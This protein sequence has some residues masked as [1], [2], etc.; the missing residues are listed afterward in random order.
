MNLPSSLTSVSRSSRSRCRS[1]RGSRGAS[2]F[3]RPTWCQLERLESRR[4]LSALGG[5]PFVS[6]MHGL[7]DGL[8]IQI[9]GVTV[10]VHGARPGGTGDEMLPLA[11]AIR[12]VGESTSIENASWLLDYD[13]SA[14]GFDPVQSIL[15]NADQVGARGELVLLYDWM[16]GANRSSHGFAEAAGDELFHMLIGLG[17]VDLDPDTA[18]FPRL[19][20]IGHGTGAVVVSKAVERLAFFGESVQ[21]VTYLDPIDWNSAAAPADGPLAGYGAAIWSNV[22]EADV[23]YQTRGANGFWPGLIDPSIPSIPSPTGRPIPGAFNYQLLDELPEN[24]IDPT[25]GYDPVNL[26]GDHDYVWEGFYLSTVND[27]QPEDNQADDVTTDTPAPQI[28]IDT[29][30]AGYAFSDLALQDVMPPPFYFENPNRGDWMEGVLYK[31]GDLVLSGDDDVLSEDD[32]FIALRTHTA[33]SADGT[34]D[35]A[36]E[37]QA[38]MPDTPG[39]SAIWIEAPPSHERVLLSSDIK[40]QDHRNSPADFVQLDD[41]IGAPNYAGLLERGLTVDDVT[42]ARWS[43]LWAPNVIFNGDLALP[44]QVSEAGMRSVPGWV[45]GSQMPAVLESFFAHATAAGVPDPHLAVGT[46]QIVTVVNSEVRLWDK[47]GVLLESQPLDDLL[48]DNDSLDDGAFDPWVIRDPY[49]GQFIVIAIEVESGTVNSDGSGGMTKGG[50]GADQ[51]NLLIAVSKTE[52]PVSL[53]ASAG[54]DWFAYK[55]EGTHDFGQGLARIDYPKVAADADSIYVTGNYA[56]FGDK[57]FQ[58]VLVQRFDKATLLAG[59]GAM[60][61]EI[62]AETVDDDD[63]VRDAFT[64]QPVQ[65]FDRDADAPQLFIEAD[66]PHIYTGAPVGDPRAGLRIW[67]MNEDDELTM[68]D[69]IAAPFSQHVGG[70]RQGASANIETLSARLMNAVWRNGSIWTAHT[71]NVGGRARVRWYEVGTEGG[72]DLVQR[73]DIDPGEAND[74]FMPAIAVTDDGQVGM[75]YTLSGFDTRPVMMFTGRTANDPD[76]FMLPGQTIRTSSDVYVPS[77]MD[78]SEERWGDYGGIDVDPTDGETLWVHHQYSDPELPFSWGTHVAALAFS[79]GPQRDPLTGA[80]ELSEDASRLSH[81]TVFVPPGATRLEVDVKRTALSLDDSLQVLLDLEPLDELGGDAFF[82]LDQIDAGFT[83][84]VFEVPFDEDVHTLTFR[85]DGGAGAIGSSVLIRDVRFAGPLVQVKAGDVS[86]I[87]VL[88][89]TGGTSVTAVTANPSH[90]VLIDPD[91]SVS[92]GVVHYAPELNVTD[93]SAEFAHS[94]SFTVTVDGEDVTVH[95]SVA[96]GHS[97]SGVNAVT[98]EEGEAVGSVFE[99]DVTN[100]TVSVAQVQH[101][102]R[103]L[104]FTGLNGATFDVD[105]SVE[106]LDPFTDAIQ[107]FVAATDPQGDG[108]DPLLED[109]LIRAGDDAHRWLNSSNAPR[110]GTIREGLRGPDIANEVFATSWAA[111]T[112]ENAVASRPE[113]LR[114][115]AFEVHGAV[116][117]SEYPDEFPVLHDFGTGHGAGMDIDW[118]LDEQLLAAAASPGIDIEFNYSFDDNGFFDPTSAEGAARREVMEAAAAFFE[119][120]QDD[121]AAIIPLGGDTWEASFFD[122]ADGSENRALLVEPNMLIPRDTIVVFAGGGALSGTDLAKAAVGGTTASGSAAFRDAAIRRGQP[123]PSRDFARWGGSVIFDSDPPQPWHT[124][125]TI[126]PPADELDLLTFAIHELGHLLGF[127]QEEF[128]PW[129]SL[130]VTGDFLGRNAM[131]VNLPPGPVRLAGVDHWLEIVVPPF[132]RTS[133]VNF[134]GASALASMNPNFAPGERVRP[135]VLDFAALT[136]IGWEHPTMD[137]IMDVLAFHQADGRGAADVKGIRIGGVSGNPDFPDIRAVLSALGVPDVMPGDGEH[138][139]FSI[140]LVPPANESIISPQEQEA[141]LNTL[142]ILRDDVTAAI[143]V[144][145]ALQADLPVTSDGSPSEVSVATSLD[146]ES[147]FA[148]VIFESVDEYFNLTSEPTFGGLQDV[149]DDLS[150]VLDHDD[151]E[152]FTEAE[153]A[154]EVNVENGTVALDLEL[155]VLQVNPINRPGSET[156]A[157]LPATAIDGVESV[158]KELTVGALWP[159]AITF[160]RSDSSVDME[161]VFFASS[162]VQFEISALS[163]HHPVGT[164]GTL[165]VEIGQ[166]TVVLEGGIRLTFDDAD[167]DTNGTIEFDELE[168]PFLANKLTTDAAGTVTGERVGTVP[169]HVG[170]GAPAP[171]AA[172]PEPDAVA[173]SHVPAACGLDAP[174]HEVSVTFQDD[175]IFDGQ[176]LTVTRSDGLSELLDRFGQFSAV[177]VYGAIDALAGLLRSVA[178]QMDIPGGIPFVAGELSANV[179]FGVIADQMA[180]ALIDSEGN[181]QFTT[182]SGMIDR[183][184]TAGGFA[185]DEVQLRCDDVESVLY[186]DLDIQ[187]D[188]NVPVAIDFG[189]EQGPLTINATVDSA[190][191][192]SIDL[193]LSVGFDFSPTTQPDELDE[194]GLR[195]TPLSDLNGLV[196]V[197]STPAGTYDVEVSTASSGAVL[198]TAD[199]YEEV[200]GQPGTTVLDAL[201]TGDIPTEMMSAFAGAGQTLSNPVL[202]APDGQATQDLFAWRIIDGDSIWQ[203]QKRAADLEVRGPIRLLDLSSL[204]E[205]STVADALNL[206]D[207]LTGGDV[208]GEVMSDEA[209]NLMLVFEDD[210]HP[211]PE[212]DPDPDAVGDFYIRRYENSRTANDLGIAG[213]DFRTVANDLL[214]D[215]SFVTLPPS[216]GDALLDRLFIDAGGG[217]TPG[218]LGLTGSIDAQQITLAASAFGVGAEVQNGRLQVDVET[219]LSIADPG[220]GGVDGRLYLKEM[221]AGSIADVADVVTTTVTGSGRLPVVGANDQ[222]NNLLFP[223]DDPVPIDVGHPE[224]PDEDGPEVVIA[225]AAAGDVDVQAN[226]LFTDRFGGFANFKLQDV[227]VSIQELV[228]WLQSSDLVA[229]NAPLPGVARSLG[230]MLDGAGQLAPALDVLCKDASSLAATIEQDI[231]PLLYANNNPHNDADNA[232]AVGALANLSAHLTVAQQTAANRLIRGVIAAAQGTDVPTM[233]DQLTASLGGLRALSDSL[234][235][236]INTTQLDAALDVLAISFPSLDRLGGLIGQAAPLAG[237]VVLSLIDLDGDAQTPGRGLRFEI[238][239]TFSFDEGVALDFDYDEPD[240]G[241]LPIGFESEPEIGFDLQASFD[242]DFAIDLTSSSDEPLDRLLVD[243]GGEGLRFSLDQASVTT[244]QAF[245]ASIGGAAGFAFNNIVASLAS[246]GGDDPVVS[247]ALADQGTIPLAQANTNETIDAVFDLDFDFSHPD[248]TGGT[249]ELELDLGGD[250]LQA[251]NVFPPLTEELEDAPQPGAG[252]NLALVGDGI[253]SFFQ[254]LVDSLQNSVLAP[255]PIL[256]DVEDLISSSNSV[257]AQLTAV[258]DAL[259]VSLEGGTIP[260]T[261]DLRSLIEDNLPDVVIGSGTGVEIPGGD[262]DDLILINLDLDGSFTI[263]TGFDLGFDAFVFEVTEDTTVELVVTYEISIG[264]GMHPVEGPFFLVNPNTD[265]INLSLDVGLSEDAAMVVD[266]FLLQASVTE[267]EDGPTTGIDGTVSLNLESDGNRLSFS[268]I[269]AAGIAGLFDFDYDLHASLG[270]TV[271]AGAGFEPDGLPHLEVDL[272]MDNWHI[273]GSGEGVFETVPAPDF[274]F[275]NARIDVGDFLSEVIGPIAGNISDFVSPLGPILDFFGLEVPLISQ[276]YQILGQDPVTVLDMVAMFGDGAETAAEFVEVVSII[277][278]VVDAAA[279]ADNGLMIHFGNFVFNDVR[280]G[281]SFDEETL[282]LSGGSLLTTDISISE[283]FDLGGGLTVSVGGGPPAP[284]PAEDADSA[285]VTAVVGKLNEIGVHFPLFENPSAFFGLLLGGEVDLVTYDGPKLGIGYQWTSPSIG[286]VAPPAPLFVNIF[287]GFEAFVDIL[288]FGVD[289]HGLREGNSLL[290]GFYLRDEGPVV[291]LGAEFGVAA[292]LNLGLVWAGIAGAIRAE[293]GAGWNSLD[294]DTKFRFSELEARLEQGLHC[295][296]DLAGQLSVILE[297]YAGLG[298]NIFGKKLTIFELEL[299]I[300]NAILL[301]FEVGCPLPEPPVL[302]HVED[303]V[304]VGDTAEDNVLVANIGPHAGRRQTGAADGD[305]VLAILPSDDPNDP[306]GTVIVEGFGESQ[307]FGPNH[308]GGQAVEYIL[309]DAGIGNDQITIDAAVTIPVM[310]IGGPGNDTLTAGGGIATINGGDGADR[311]TGGDDNDEIHGGAGNDLIFGGDG[312]DDL[313]GDDG[314]DTI[315]AEDGNDNAW[316]GDGDDRLDGSIGTDNLR[317]DGG[318]DQISGGPD[319]DD[320]WGGPGDDSLTGNAGDDDLFGDAGKDVLSGGAGSDTLDGGAGDDTLIGDEDGSSGD[321]VGATY[322]DI[323]TGGDGSDVLDGGRGDDTYRFAAVTDGSSEKDRISEPAN[324][325]GD[326]ADVLDFS[327]L[328]ADGDGDGNMDE[329]AKE[330]GVRVNLF[331]GV[332]RH[333]QRKIEI[334]GTRWIEHVIGGAGPDTFVDNA[335]S[336]TFTGGGGNDVYF[337]GHFVGQVADTQLDRVVEGVGD[338]QDEINFADLPAG[339]PVHVDL[340]DGVASPAATTTAIALHNTRTVETAVQG[341]KNHIENITGGRAADILRGNASANIIVGNGAD[342]TIHGEGGG[343]TIR[344]NAGQDTINGGSGPDTIYGGAGA[345]DINGGA[346]GD[347]IFG[348]GGNDTIRGQG[349]QDIIEGGT[350]EDLIFGNAANDT[351]GGGPDPDT[352]FG[353]GGTD[354]IDGDGGADTIFGGNGRP[355]DQG[356][357][358]DT[359]DILR[360]NG[361]A[362]LLFGE[363]GGDTID[364]GAGRDFIVGDIG[365]DRLTGGS[366]NDFLTGGIDSGNRL[367]DPASPILG[368]G[369]FGDWLDGEGNHDLVIGGLPADYLTLQTLV[370]DNFKDLFDRETRIPDDGV[371]DFTDLLSVYQADPTNEAFL[372][373]LA[374]Y[375]SDGIDNDDLLHGGSGNDLLAGSEGDDN[376]YGDH[377]LDTLFGWRIGR[378]DVTTTDRYEGGPDNDLLCGTHGAN[379]MVGGTSDHNIHYI[380]EDPGDPGGPHA[381]GYD[382]PACIDEDP[383]LLDPDPV[384]IHGQKW[385]DANGNGTRDVDEAGQDGWTIQLRDEEGDLIASTV[386]SS[387]DLNEDGIIDPITERGLYW[388]RDLSVEGGNVEEFQAATYIVSEAL[389]NGF[390]QTQPVDGDQLVDEPGVSVTAREMELAVSGDTLTTVVYAVDVDEGQTASGVN[391]GNAPLASI[392]GHKFEDLNNDGVQDVGEPVLAGWEVTLR[393]TGDDEFEMVQVTDGFGEYRF[394]NLAPGH[395]IVEETDNQ[396]G[397][398]WINS[399]PSPT[400]GFIVRHV[401]VDFGDIVGDEDFGN[402]HLTTVQGHVWNDSDGDRQQDEDEPPVLHVGGPPV[403]LHDVQLRN[404]NGDV[405]DSVS[406][407]ED[408]NYFFEGVYPGFYTVE[409]DSPL[410]W[411]QTFPGD[412]T[413][414]HHHIL[415]ESSG[416]FEGLDF[417]TFERGVASGTKFDDL[418]AD[419]NQDVDE[420]TELGGGLI[421]WND[422]DGDGRMDEQDEPGMAGVVIYVD[423][424]DNGILDVGEEGEPLEPTATTVDDIPITPEDETG[425]YDFLNLDPGNY[426]IREVV[427]DGFAQTFPDFHAESGRREHRIT[428]RSGS[429]EFGQQSIEGLDFGNVA[430][431]TIDGVKWND[432]NGNG[433]RDA[434]ELGLGNW[435]I[436]LDLDD[437]GVLTLD[438]FGDPA[439]PFT[440]TRYDDPDTPQDELGTYRFEGVFPGNYTVRE[441]LQPNWLQTW[442]EAGALPG[443]HTVNVTGGATFSDRNFGNVRA[444]SIHGTKWHD[445]DADGVFDTY[446]DG[447]A[448]VTIYLDLND[449]RMRDPGEPTQVT[450][451]DDPATLE[452]ETGMYWFDGLLPGTYVIRE[453]E[454]EGYVQTYPEGTNTISDVTFT[455]A[456]TVNQVNGFIPGVWSATAVGQPW[457]VSYTF[458]PT[459]PDTLVAN[460]TLGN[461]EAIHEFTLTVGGASVTQSPNPANTDIDVRDEQGFSGGIVI[462]SFEKGPQQGS[463]ALGVNAFGTTLNPE[464]VVG[465]SRDLWSVREAGDGI[466][467]AEVR[468]GALHILAAGVDAAVS[469]TWDGGVEREIGDGAMY[470]PRADP[471]AAVDID[472]LGADNAG[473]NLSQSGANDA[474]FVDILSL[475]GT[476]SVRVDVWSDGGTQFQSQVA[477]IAGAAPQTLI[478]FTAAFAGIDWT[479]VSALK[480]TVD[481]QQTSFETII[482]AVRMGREITVPQLDTYTAGGPVQ[483]ADPGDPN[484]FPMRWSVHTED[485]TATA[486][487][488]DANPLCAEYHLEDFGGNRAFR[489]EY[490]FGSAVGSVETHDC[491]VELTTTPGAHIVELGPGEVVDGR[492]FGNTLASEIQGTVWH[493]AD[494]DGVRDPDETPAAGIDVFLDLNRNGKLDRDPLTVA[495]IEPV[496]SSQFDDP[497]T[498]EDETGRYAFTRLVTDIYLVRQVTPELQMQTYPRRETGYLH[499]VPLSEGELVTQ[500]DFGNALN[501]GKVAPVAPYNAAP[502]TPAVQ[503]ADGLSTIGASTSN[504]STSG[505]SPRSVAEI[506]AFQTLAEPQ[507]IDASFVPSTAPQAAALGTSA[508]TPVFLGSIHHDG[509]RGPTEYYASGNDDSLAEYGIAGYVFT[510]ADFGLAANEL[511]DDITLVELM[512]THNNRPFTDGNGVELFL[513]TQVFGGDYTGLTFNTA[514]VNGIDGSQYNDP[515]VS[516]GVFPTLVTPISAG[517]DFFAIDLGVHEPLVIDKI[518]SGEEFGILIGAINPTYDITYSGLGNPFD[519]GDPLLRIDVSAR[520]PSSIHGFKYEDLDGDGQRDENEPAVAGVTVYSDLNNNNQLDPGEPSTTTTL[521]GTWWLTDL[522]PQ[523]HLVREV[524]PAGMVQT[525]PSSGVHVVALADGQTVDGLP[526]GNAPLGEIHGTKWNDGDGDGIR[527]RDEMGVAGVTV[528]IDENNNG[529]RDAGELWTVTM[530]DNPLTSAIDETGA[531]WLTGLVPGLHV[532]REVMPDGQVQTFPATANGIPQAHVVNLGAGQ[533]VEDRDFGNAP[534]ISGLKFVDDHDCL[535]DYSPL[536]LD[537]GLAGVT[538]YLDLNDNGILDGSEPMQVTMNDDENTPQNEAGRYFF[539]GLLP[540]TYTVREVVPDGMLQSFPHPDFEGIY[541]HTVVINHLGQGVGGVNF[542]N[543]FPRILADGADE[544]FGYDANDEIYGDN[545]VSNRCVFSIGDD[546]TTI[547]G[548]GDDIMAGQLR[549]DDYL[550]EAATAENEEDT[551]IELES[552]GV[553]TPL[554]DFYGFDWQRADEGFDDRLNFSMLTDVQPVTIDLSGTVPSWL[555][556]HQVARYSALAGGVNTVAT[557]L[558]EQHDYIENAFGGDGNDRITGNVADN[559]FDGGAGDDVMNGL[560]GDDTYHHR[561]HAPGEQD[562]VDDTGGVDTLDLR[563]I[564]DDTTVD[565]S[566]GVPDTIATFAGQ[567]IFSNDPSQFD[568]VLTGAGNDTITG[569][570]NDNRIESGGGANWMNGLTGDDTLIGGPQNDTYVFADDWGMDEVIEE[571]DGGSLDTM[572]FSQVTADVHHQLGSLTSTAGV[573]T[574]THAG[575]YVERLIGNPGGDTLVGPAYES[576]WNITGTDTGIVNDFLQFQGIGILQGR[577]DVD[578]IFVFSDGAEISGT[579]SGGDGDAIDSLDYSDYSTPLSLNLDDGMVSGVTGGVSGI[580][581]VIG[582]GESTDTLTG[583]N[584]DATWTI[585]D[586]NAGHVRTDLGVWFFAGFENLIGQDGNDVFQLSDERGVSG[587]INGGGG[588]NTLNYSPEGVP[589]VLPYTIEITVDLLTHSATNIGGG[590]A[591][592][593]NFEGGLIGDTLI[594]L[595]EDS[596]WNITGNNR[597]NINGDVRFLGFENL[598]GRDNFDDTFRFGVLGG[599][600]GA[601]D[602]G[603]GSGDDTIDYSAYLFRPATVNLADGSVLGIE[604]LIGGSTMLDTLIGLDAQSTWSITADN[605]GNID[606]LMGIQNIS[607]QG[608]ENL[609]GRDDFN[610]V[611]VLSDGSG[612]SGAIDGGSGDATDTLDYSDYA[613]AVVN[614]TDGTATN[615]NGGV[616]QIEEFIGVNEITLNAGADAD[617]GV[618][619]SFFVDRDATHSFVTVNEQLVFLSPAASAPEITVEGSSDDDTLNVSFANGDPIS[620]GL[621][622][623]GGSQISADTLVVFG[624]GDQSGVYHPDPTTF[625]NGTIT[626]GSTTIE[627]TGL[628]PVVIHDLQSVSFISPGSR[629]NVIVDSPAPNQN[630]IRGTSDGLPFEE[631]VFENVPE[632]VIDL[633]QNDIDGMGDDTITFESDLVATNLQMLALVTSDGDTTDTSQVVSFQPLPETELL[634]L[635]TPTIRAAGDFNGD[636]QVNAN[637]IDRLF[638]AIGRSSLN[639]VFDVNQDFQL[640]DDDA[641]FLIEE[642]LRTLRGDANLD[643]SVDAIDFGVWGNN[644]F[645]A[646]TGWATGDFNGDGVTDGTDFNFWIANRFNSTPR[647]GALVDDK[648]DY[649]PRAPHVP[650]LLSDV[651]VSRFPFMT[652]DSASGKH[653]TQ[654][655]APRL[656]LLDRWFSLLSPKTLWRRVGRFRADGVVMPTLTPMDAMVKD[657]DEPHLRSQPP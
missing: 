410:G 222:I 623:H 4:L 565:L 629:D 78:V 647:A 568:T 60:P 393:R 555:A 71:V 430:A 269:G 145:D 445:A 83:T 586:N 590:F 223:D 382:V 117:V 424:N 626:V 558:S 347:T 564:G 601:M 497:T 465:E 462:D 72:F 28:P 42:N 648:G 263:D 398:G 330:D 285:T 363:F 180:S 496:V 627:F 406:T 461:Y 265:E 376:L 237:D 596:S 383:Q 14:G 632:I 89:L 168:D 584:G 326:S 523:T 158:L 35:F 292:E 475:T 174:V 455:F 99:D 624:A 328:P 224:T 469:V 289:T 75:T 155:E 123:E 342:D 127:G 258:A 15:P 17:V 605:A 88:A 397:D 92:E 268:E 162:G 30:S 331:T 437:D 313:Y 585:T 236:S 509:D 241:L 170:G 609:M 144:Q 511:V 85:I 183:L 340:T 252:P 228:G 483:P 327:M 25:N 651:V 120:F 63:Q 119:V 159:M 169:D 165:E 220:T 507:P 126:P 284:G 454:P 56:R 587:V 26:V 364:G 141:F 446:E 343:D 283:Q 654:W 453:V 266:L 630:R 562:I 58:G 9:E 132:I 423:V 450:M 31:E 417:G 102:L 295:V 452:D 610:D 611:F 82:E 50:H 231:L 207:V 304:P 544:I 261:D 530:T 229:L 508:K 173:A 479:D 81:Q 256:G 435:T 135:T 335:L 147:A 653:G 213:T 193:Q 391:F 109:S 22:Q 230:D 312:N 73:G 471:L 235:D 556:D 298:I 48:E 517:V 527:D 64:L 438:P 368:E 557:D 432:L 369:E 407:D 38:N 154:A 70:A 338:G 636:E 107:L 575:D 44:G 131:A 443:G 580:E 77:P 473:V 415:V 234:P 68:V 13:A 325:S 176:P 539:V 379:F 592:I 409:L 65:S 187:R 467:N 588:N 354:E 576:I 506:P 593:A 150:F 427:P 59:G 199:A 500:R 420:V 215:G 339:D 515:P 39:G 262:S 297:A 594:G 52:T 240:S 245:G 20:F 519:P 643:G 5:A 440:T 277:K 350:G 244:G 401:T 203:V 84:I 411:T 148:T 114:S 644:R 650:Q 463:L 418:N 608:F 353:N 346:Q 408:G 341:Q 545:L 431:G 637:D 528:Y 394:E 574:A 560:T 51:A 291:G 542:G 197:R 604:T 372:A 567:S 217:G 628:E 76:G 111:Q 293:I 625:G 434:G 619:D 536:E 308:E 486:F 3:V 612:V 634:I 253:T 459:V 510:K 16:E 395:Y 429:D 403:S 485:P 579:I 209:G 41:R 514:L 57:E 355:V 400:E 218:S 321:P 160:E 139:Y 487:E 164:A 598:T 481:P 374:M 570:A 202:E 392:S 618:A 600:S 559:W 290:D 219:G 153:L 40:I 108:E 640:D 137:A 476:A 287:A 37:P 633:N 101:R 205:S 2:H 646:G 47:A 191:N 396:I 142:T 547:G 577:D 583:P 278:D 615:V 655:T 540:G 306:D 535:G 324:A 300:L 464:P 1:R 595:G 125:L 381:G 641:T 49:S 19:H 62:V 613:A 130:S 581:N 238:P 470:D 589:E 188:V 303:G 366:G 105:G 247:F 444:A 80:L 334:K 12:D 489:L 488:D 210:T 505:S 635:V 318:D 404:A 264:F 521:D 512:L 8:D 439:E 501:V 143:M 503:N 305:D 122:P 620:N 94:D 279:D 23:Y 260:D 87:D 198:F 522:P 361:G 310:L 466:V 614:L 449:N 121:L 642:I 550:F 468:D 186:L 96:D 491:D 472:G 447:L 316:G 33:R 233:V 358:N 548:E 79:D 156:S 299:E 172:A 27:Q 478:F 572:D 98:I 140:D 360:G 91:S 200:A 257:F 357:G 275:E 399:L 344:G 367:T 482:D 414:G 386:T 502:N 225:I 649:V 380:L 53:D 43:P 10:I 296:F 566:S 134:Q 518:N 189:L 239:M 484:D 254:G 90:G 309:V 425:R 276:I 573:N 69:E 54:G 294:D 221:F 7:F 525:E 498:R 348:D 216:V 389:Q 370:I 377:G 271:A 146:L 416:T 246:S 282:S 456:G 332:A 531:Y 561:A 115:G 232:E 251:N 214:G 329:G 163:T 116:A 405:I 129:Q 373:L 18:D 458:D 201:R 302:A 603:G 249:I 128:Q 243:T 61:T 336:N 460:S 442:P 413:G 480:L 352:I 351:I 543:Y 538:I 138:A 349:G 104:G 286:T 520:V 617:D 255:L 178:P 250:P 493:D 524:V 513:T 541:Y 149:L 494:A 259:A 448:G 645:T 499:I 110:W 639:P 67:E 190:F 384:Q 563:Q 314:D 428:Y 319:G 345:D 534:G 74:T 412:E 192:A 301:S 591:N 549:H 182:F 607:F 638:R 93:W 526:F 436:F 103:Y 226:D 492:D 616:S 490:D 362:D 227:C 97:T 390:G 171:D 569:N 533:I 167:T 317:G 177:D 477:A 551:I 622:Y 106:P 66:A 421:I 553:P 194:D 136:D 206:I 451:E 315:Q 402:V 323:L 11:K 118:E 95:V 422:V 242:L 211:D 267:K 32:I 196:G 166:S 175:D 152:G 34:G 212:T 333:H 337:F 385:F 100:P 307:K 113:L 529:Q 274:R 631:L 578:D 161:Q 365:N 185:P 270:L 495:Q 441:V 181:L 320:L 133:S 388:F 474:I 112:I 371:E 273:L 248:I 378:V 606:D 151:E 45:S 281:A 359:G 46:D 387:V 419:G 504:A 656:Q 375:T 29:T 55:V 36:P 356:A 6:D 21:Q 602:G 86:T 184:S 532:V 621:T 552:T 288:H 426:V 582:A 195:A 457:E 433:V 124:D 657:V 571:Q 311:L 204:S 280:A 546:D 157:G 208:T 597:G 272:V 322:D 599:L 652:K 554:A 516:L 24:P 179:D 537:Q